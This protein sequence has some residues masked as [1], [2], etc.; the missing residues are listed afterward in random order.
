M[1]DNITGIWHLYTK[2]FLTQKE[3]RYWLAEIDRRKND[4]RRA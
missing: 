1:L 4:A 2:G 3:V